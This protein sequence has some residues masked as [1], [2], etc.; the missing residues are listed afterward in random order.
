MR[1][2]FAS[3]LLSLLLVTTLVWGGC[4]SCEQYF[5]WPGAK[6]CCAPDGH[7]KTK[8]APAKQD[9]A[10]ECKLIAFDHQK[11]IDHHIDLAVVA[12]VAVDLAIRSVEAFERWHGTSPIEP[13]PPDLQILHST[14]LI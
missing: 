5:M 1:R 12:A 6:T 10:R 11:S 7:C 2:A 3:S 8:K 13:S 4:I 14:L 9:S